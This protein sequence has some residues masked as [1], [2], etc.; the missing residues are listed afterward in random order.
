MNLFSRSSNPT[1]QQCGREELLRPSVAAA[2]LRQNTAGAK[3]DGRG[4]G[5]DGV[6]G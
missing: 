3:K 5:G 6:S 4:G 1:H 2:V